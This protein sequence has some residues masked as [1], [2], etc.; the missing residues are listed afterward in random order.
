MKTHHIL[1]LTSLLIS[2][3]LHSEEGSAINAAISAVNP[4]V[5]SSYSD[6]VIIPD[7]KGI[8]VFGS[9]FNPSDVLKVQAEGVVISEGLDVPDK[10][11]FTEFLEKRLHTSI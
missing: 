9:D 8:A 7:V 3:S 6:K 10:A 11:A 4:V 2:T 1:C 5:E